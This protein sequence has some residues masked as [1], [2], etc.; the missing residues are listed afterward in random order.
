[1]SDWS[2]IA[3]SAAIPAESAERIA[4]RLTALEEKLAPLFAKLTP[5]M[6]PAVLFR[7]E[8]RD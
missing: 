5:D 6:E 3:R 1:M 8:D 7:M 2:S 4:S